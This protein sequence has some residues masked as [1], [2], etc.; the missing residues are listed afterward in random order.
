MLAL[1]SLLSRER[2]SDGGSWGER[3]SRAGLGARGSRWKTARVGSVKG[4]TLF[5]GSG[6]LVTGGDFR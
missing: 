5:L 4:I 6:Y 3:I 2:R 1:V